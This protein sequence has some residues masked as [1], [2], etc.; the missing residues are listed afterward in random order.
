MTCDIAVHCECKNVSCT[1]TLSQ[2]ALYCWPPSA[3][4]NEMQIE[5]H[6]PMFSYSLQWKCLSF[7]FPSLTWQQL[8]YCS[9]SIDWFAQHKALQAAGLYCCFSKPLNLYHCQDSDISPCS[10][11]LCS[12]M[13]HIH[14]IGH[15]HSET[16]HSWDHFYII[17]HLH[18]SKSQSECFV[19]WPQRRP[20]CRRNRRDECSS[21]RPVTLLILMNA[22]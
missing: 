10:A 4:Y 12:K 2:S 5:W 19:R 15:E 11:L 16:L 17:C 14:I 6:L 21:D 3:F 7:N 9:I 18:S 8:L 1:D 20:R 13:I 22:Y